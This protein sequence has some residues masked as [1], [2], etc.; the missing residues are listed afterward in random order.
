MIDLS[1]Q[2]MKVDPKRSTIEM[3]SRFPGE[4]PRAHGFRYP[5]IDALTTHNPRQSP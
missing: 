5:F 3:G 1:R 2:A 4:F